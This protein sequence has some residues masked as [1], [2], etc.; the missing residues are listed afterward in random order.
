ME[1]AGVLE[2]SDEV[3]LAAVRDELREIAGV[4]AKPR[5]WRIARWPRSMAQY[6]VGHPQRVTEIEA[7]TAAIPG[8][9]LA[10]NA[11]RGIGVPDCIR[12]GKAA[13]Q[14]ILSG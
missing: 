13:A 6:A 5:F 9:Y 4:T 14:A 3:V 1:D 10:G 2:E 8:L 11:Y 7:R 12:M